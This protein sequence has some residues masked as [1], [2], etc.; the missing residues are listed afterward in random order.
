MKKN[1][2]FTLVEVMVVVVILLILTGIVGGCVVGG[3][4]LVKGGKHVQEH[5]IKGTATELW[6]GPSSNAPAE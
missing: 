5:G 3:C 4:L 6:E 1:S 2:G